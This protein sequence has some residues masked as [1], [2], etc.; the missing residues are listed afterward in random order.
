MATN[1]NTGIEPISNSNNINNSLPMNNNS[2]PSMSPGSSPMDIELNNVHSI[3]S[4]VS[5]NRKR[6]HSA[7]SR[8]GS[9]GSNR[10]STYRDTK[11]RRTMTKTY[12]PY[13][14]PI[15][16][17]IYEYM[18]PKFK[19]NLKTETEDDKKINDMTSFNG[20]G[21]DNYRRLMDALQPEGDY[22]YIFLD[23]NNLSRSNF[24]VRQFSKMAKI[25]NPGTQF[26]F[27]HKDVPNNDIVRRMSS[28]PTTPNGNRHSEKPIVSYKNIT[29]II[30][31]LNHG[32]DNYIM[33]GTCDN[34]HAKNFLE[35]Y[36]W[37][38]WD[39]PSDMSSP[40]FKIKT[41]NHLIEVFKFKSKIKNIESKIKN[42]ILY[43]ISVQ[44]IRKIMSSE[45][46]DYL[47]ISLA[48]DIRK[49]IETKLMCGY[50][51]HD[52]YSWINQ[53]TA[54]TNFNDIFKQIV[55][56]ITYIDKKLSF[57]VR[58]NKDHTN[59]L[60]YIKDMTS[61]ANSRPTIR[62]TRHSRNSRNSSNNNTRRTIRHSRT[63]RNS[64]NNKNSRT[65]V[66][67]RNRR[68]S[69]TSINSA[70]GSN[71]NTQRRQRLLSVFSRM[72]RLGSVPEKS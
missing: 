27:N 70:S 6:P 49:N 7:V 41:T 71:N 61:P 2:V 25:T 64:R 28:Q 22:N 42:N 5:Q 52:K 72:D 40:M 18:M 8:S 24:A 17:S 68:N 50:L 44:N 34:S 53:F 19:E 26:D 63:S 32:L 35:N 39:G 59:H 30:D 31:L 36:K 67:S 60:I 21:I 9:N 14:Q 11:R 4:S 15:P 10:S 33:V 62:N 13:T 54:N 58:H 1:T 12:K 20:I 37:V 3:S 46:D 38:S 56:R 48:M 66:N 16:Y 29:E 43:L 65:R 69:R 45:L 51:S 23:M 47:L 57:E 55:Y